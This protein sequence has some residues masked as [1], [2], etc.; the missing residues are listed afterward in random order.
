LHEHFT[1]SQKATCSILLWS[2]GHRPRHARA[3][4][5]PSQLH[6]SESGTGFGGGINRF[7]RFAAIDPFVSAAEWTNAAFD[8]GHQ[9][10]SRPA[11]AAAGLFADR[12]IRANFGQRH[13]NSACAP[14][15]HYFGAFVML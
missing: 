4:A 7:V 10:K 5:L 3:R 11:L 8:F 6:E 1:P 14:G 12:A 9:P 15:R 13:V 2:V